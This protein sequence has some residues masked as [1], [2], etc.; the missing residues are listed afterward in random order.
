MRLLGEHELMLEG[1]SIAIPEVYLQHM[2]RRL[3]LGKPEEGDYLAEIW[4]A[5]GEDVA[6]HTEGFVPVEADEAGYIEVPERF[7]KAAQGLALVLCGND[8][9]LELWDAGVWD[10]FCASMGMDDLDFLF[11]EDVAEPEE[12]VLGDDVR[13][14]LEAV[15]DARMRKNLNFR[16]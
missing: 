6:A 8:D 1:N 10:A 7:L 14:A 11:G 4:S 2:G 13:R 5:A 3:L 9:H 15:R 12:D 16:G